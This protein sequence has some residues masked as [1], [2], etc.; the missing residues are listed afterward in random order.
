MPLLSHSELFNILF[1]IRMLK[2]FASLSNASLLDIMLSFL[3][4]YILLFVSYD[5]LYLW[6]LITRAY[7]RISMFIFWLIYISILIYLT[8]MPLIRVIN[9]F[10]SRYC[11]SHRFNSNAA[12]STTLCTFTEA[13][14][15]ADKLLSLMLNA[16]R[17]A[18]PGRRY[19][20]HSPKS[21]IS[22]PSANE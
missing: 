13:H 6:L 15:T 5:F 2:I 7:I 9:L 10:L 22:P 8:T 17:H 21:S 12:A 19:A 3:I 20:R 16:T 14:P 18:S 4:L 11:P 1:T